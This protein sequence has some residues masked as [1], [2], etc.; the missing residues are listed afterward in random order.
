MVQVVRRTY[1]KILHVEYSNL[2]MRVFDLLVYVLIYETMG[3]DDLPVPAQLEA[4]LGKCKT[5]R[6]ASEYYKSRDK[7]TEVRP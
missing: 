2:T 6:K 1:F 5:V 3:D 7:T 4:Q